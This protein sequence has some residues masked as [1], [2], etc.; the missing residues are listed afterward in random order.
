MNR[1]NKSRAD[2][3]SEKIR[4]QNIIILFASEVRELQLLIFYVFYIL[5]FSA[6]AHILFYREV[7]G[8][9]AYS[10]DYQR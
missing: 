9:W 8:Q 4:E 7:S 5:P 10:V 3:F 6:Q 1:R 2:P